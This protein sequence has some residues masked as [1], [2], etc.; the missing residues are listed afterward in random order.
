MK[1]SSLAIKINAEEIA[2]RV[3]DEFTYEGKT[4]RQIVSE[5]KELK[6][7]CTSEDFIKE[8]TEAL[9][10]RDRVIECR[11]SG[12]R[13]CEFF[14]NYDMEENDCSQYMEVM[15]FEELLNGDFKE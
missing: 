4:L 7:K 1:S 5:L 3:L 14:E 15:S 2:E 6:D 9:N 8:I 12:Y 10:L 11:D 13:I